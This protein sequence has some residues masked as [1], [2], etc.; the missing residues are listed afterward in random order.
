MRQPSLHDRTG[1]KGMI[2]ATLSLTEIIE[3]IMQTTKQKVELLLKNLPDDCS[4]EDVQ[5]HLYVLTKVLMGLEIANSQGGITQD[6][7]EQVLGKW[8]IQ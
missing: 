1:G 2:A 6:Q 7:A 8:L 5:Y 4:L 3:E